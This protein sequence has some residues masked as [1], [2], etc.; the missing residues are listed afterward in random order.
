MKFINRGCEYSD[1]K[2]SDTP[3]RK[4]VREG[5]DRGCGKGGDEGESAE[6][7]RLG[8]TGGHK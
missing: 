6:R 2:S 4:G 1:Y 3:R 8:G 5:G 7:M